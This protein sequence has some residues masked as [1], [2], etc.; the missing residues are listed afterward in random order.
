VASSGDFFYKVIIYSCMASNVVYY[1]NELYAISLF[2][3]FEMQVG[4]LLNGR[5][6][7]ECVYWELF[8]LIVDGKT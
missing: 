8:G 5:V 4:F 1:F 6:D 2:M 3:A 7:S